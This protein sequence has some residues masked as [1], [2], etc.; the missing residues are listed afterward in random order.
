MQWQALER[1]LEYREG[2]LAVS[3]VYRQKVSWALEV[4]MWMAVDADCLGL[5]GSTGF[6]LWVM[7]IGVGEGVSV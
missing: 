2:M 6:A 3:P 5:S 7:P 4:Y 1:N